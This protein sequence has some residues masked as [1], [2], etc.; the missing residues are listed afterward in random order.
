MPR[1]VAMGSRSGRTARS[2]ERMFL[3]WASTVRHTGFRRFPR[4]VHQLLAA[5]DPAGTFDEQAEEPVLPAG[6][7][8]RLAE[9]RDVTPLFIDLERQPARR[10]GMS[11]SLPLSLLGIF[12]LLSVASCK[13][14]EG[15]RI[16]LPPQQI[17]S[18]VPRDRVRVVFFNTSS[19]AL[20][21]ESGWIR[22]RLDG[23]TVPTLWIDEYTQIFAEPGEHELLLE[24]YDLFQFTDR[25]TVHFSGK[26]IFLEVWCRPI[27]TQFRQIELLPPEFSQRFSVARDPVEWNAPS[28][29]QERN[30]HE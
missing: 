26:E 28:A 8:Q 21:F 27:S 22:I 24:H 14:A 25:Y 11:R 16:P 12:T 1:C 29:P 19:R 13:T 20:Y 4:Q 2:L 10:P 6:Q 9:V 3:M 5:V 17:S 7:I 30:S 23:R 15:P 18:E